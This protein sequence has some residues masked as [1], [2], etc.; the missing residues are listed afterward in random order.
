MATRALLRKARRASQD[1]STFYGLV[2]RHEHTQELLKPAPHQRLMFSFYEHHAR[3]VFRQ[4][5]GTAKT[6]SMAAIM[7]WEMGRDATQRGA[8]VSKTR[9][10]SQKPLMM[11]SDY[12]TNQRLNQRLGLVFPNL[13]RS[14]RPQDPWSQNKL[15]IARPPGIRDPTLTALGFESSIEGARLSWLLGD[16]II[17]EEN[18][19]TRQAREKVQSLFEGRM[20]SR[21]D[22]MGSK[23][24]VTNTPWNRED[25]TYYLENEAGWPCITMNVY[26]D[27]RITNADQAWLASVQGVHVRPSKKKPGWYR[28]VAHD[29]DPDEEIPLWPDRYDAKWIRETRYGGNGRTQMLPNQFAKLF[30]CEPFDEGAARCKREWVESCKQ[31][32]MQTVPSYNGPNPTFTGVDISIGQSSSNDLTVFFT[33]ELLRDGRRCILDVESGRWDGHALVRK[34]ITK[35]DRYKSLV[36]VESVAAQDFIRQ[37]ALKQRPDLMIRGHR[38]GRDKNAVDFGVESI[39]SEIQNGAWMIPADINGQCTP[40]IQAWIDGMVSYQPPPAH[41]SDHLMACWVAREHARR[42]GRKDP[43]HS[44]GRKFSIEASPGGF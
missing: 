42:G 13:Q 29:P 32:G 26:G 5:I 4:P 17:D 2:M 10:Q 33:F 35:H 23:V 6:F 40:D 15:T 28:L 1:L 34:L 8:I 9:N 31:I 30:L 7:L 11:V 21:M 44:V 37:W 39:F 41:T 3:C 36:I 25:L 43:K 38:T 22:P 19:A 24:A 27:I 12:I 18:S 14:S 20:L 16:D